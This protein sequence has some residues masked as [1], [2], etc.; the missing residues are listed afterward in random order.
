M[1]I[2]WL[3]EVE[4]KDDKAKVIQLELKQKPMAKNNIL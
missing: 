3:F 1:N 2:L 4:V